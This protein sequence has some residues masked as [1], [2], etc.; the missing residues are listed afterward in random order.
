MSKAS[1]STG[2]SG[3]KSSFSAPSK[4]GTAVEQRTTKAQQ[5]PTLF[6]TAVEQRSASPPKG[7]NLID[8]NVNRRNPYTGPRA[9]GYETAHPESY[10]PAYQT[11]D[12]SWYRPAYWH[13]NQPQEYLDYIQEESRKWTEQ[14]A[15]EKAQREAEEKARIEKYE[16]DREYRTGVA[17]QESDKRYGGQKAYPSPQIED[18]YERMDAPNYSYK[19]DAPTQNSNAGDLSATYDRNTSGLLS[20]LLGDSARGVA[21]LQ[22]GMSSD[23]QS[24]IEHE[25]QTR[26]AQGGVGGNQLEQEGLAQ[27]AQLYAQINDRGKSQMGLAQSLQSAR[28]QDHM[29][30]MQT[31]AQNNKKRMGRGSVGF[32]EADMNMRNMFDTMFREGLFSTQVEDPY[33]GIPDVNKGPP[34]GRPRWL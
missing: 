20:G 11:P 9:P 22:R 28:L 21:D 23:A 16:K 18:T 33:Q 15:R 17:P 24:Q 13:G 7:L 27:Q 32:R 31:W 34:I 6:G 29:S 8:L 26:N 3:T 25:S 12:G 4:P 10:G 5:P 30:Q 1:T 2:K 19:N 14:L